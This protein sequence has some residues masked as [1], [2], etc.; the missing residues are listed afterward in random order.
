MKVEEIKGTKFTDIKK[1]EPFKLNG[2]I[3][4]K[5]SPDFQQNCV[6]LKTGDWAVMDDNLV[7]PVKA[8]VVIE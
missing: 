2:D 5:T 1:G 6:N 3:F 7:E 4:I 8:K